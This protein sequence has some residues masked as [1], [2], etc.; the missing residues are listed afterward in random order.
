MNGP[1]Y[2][3]HRA[4]KSRGALSLIE[5]L[6]S[7]LILGGSVTIALVAQSNS[8]VALENS[9]LQLIA[10]HAAK[11]LI[12]TWTTED[13]ILT[14]PA[15]GTLPDTPHWTW[16]RASQR[17]SVSNGVAVME[18]TLRLLN[19]HP[20]HQAAPWVREYRWWIND[21]KP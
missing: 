16:C 21:A 12:A 6:A 15:C 14:E 3:S 20:N 17:V 2:N 13:E 9:R 4:G 10:Q 1:G 8:L 11:E 5:V 18:I 7:L 19:A